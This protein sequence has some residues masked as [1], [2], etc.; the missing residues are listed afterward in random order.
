MNYEKALTNLTLIIAVLAALAASVG[1]FTDEG[2][3]EYSYKSIRGET[4]RIYG[5]GIYQ[6]MSADVAIQGIAQDYVTLFAA[7]PLLLVALYHSRKG[8]LRARFLLAGVLFY[9]LVTYLF[10]LTMGMY[11]YLF[12][13]YAT[14]LCCSFFALFLTLTELNLADL[15]DYFSSDRTARFSGGYL[16]FSAYSVAF[17]WLGVVIPPLLDGFIFPKSLEHY[18][19]LI[20]Q[21]LDLGLLLPIS[22]VVGLMLFRRQRAGFLF[23]LPYLIFLSLLMSALTAK[24]IA[25]ALNGVNVIPVIF[26]MPTFAMIAISS[27]WRMLKSIHQNQQ[28]EPYTFYVNKTDGRR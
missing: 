9:F 28:A 19:T 18:T 8:S 6:H 12:L 15:D 27:A 4:V 5:K 10:Y 24:I 22:F 23:G 3:G 14:L 17:L 13:V 26:I 11:N 7:V 21:G 25:M 20:V 1:I 16:I 2:P